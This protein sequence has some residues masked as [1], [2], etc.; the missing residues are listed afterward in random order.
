MSNDRLNGAVA[1]SSLPMA[2]L[3]L[4][5]GVALVMIFWTAD[6]MLN[7][8]HA[9]AV[10]ANF[11]GL[12]GLGD[13]ALLLIGIGQALVVAAFTVGAFKTVSYGA[14]LLMHTV[15][16]LSSWRQYIDPFDNLLFLAAWPMLA[17]C[18]TLFLL[19]GHDRLLAVERRL[20]GRGALRNE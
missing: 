5:L 8:D 10:F 6:K 17:A 1:P 18:M 13:S 14:I 15:S 11:Y 16:T 7:P 2:L 4:R 3:L 19:R 20:H 12:G 9:G